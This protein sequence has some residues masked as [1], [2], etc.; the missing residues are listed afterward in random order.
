LRTSVSL[1]LTSASIARRSVNA[2]YPFIKVATA[3]R[4][5]LKGIAFCL[6]A[7]SAWLRL[8]Q[9]PWLTFQRLGPVFTMGFSPVAGRVWIPAD[10]LLSIT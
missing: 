9:I 6:P 10:L 4:G 2:R 1:A 7:F 3:G 5:C 8:L